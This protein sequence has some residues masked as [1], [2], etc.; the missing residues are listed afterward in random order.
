[1]DAFC[2]GFRYIRAKSVSMIYS[3]IVSIANYMYLSRL[4][5]MIQVV[6]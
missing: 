4:K 3:H 2:P 1:M 6:Y 5:K